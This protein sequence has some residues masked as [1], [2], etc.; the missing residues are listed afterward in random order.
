LDKARRQEL[1][2]VE[3]SLR[4]PLSSDNGFQGLSI[5]G[6]KLPLVFHTSINYK[7]L[8]KINALG[9]LELPYPAVAKSIG[10]ID[11]R[12]IERNVE[13]IGRVRT[14]DTLIWDRKPGTLRLGAVW[15]DGIDFMDEDTKIEPGKRYYF[16][17]TMKMPPASRWELSKVE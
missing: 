6:S 10:M 9:Q 13:L 1:N 14:G 17:Y 4:N 3:I 12:L 8:G 16:H 5:P 7:G 11:N 2:T 15:H